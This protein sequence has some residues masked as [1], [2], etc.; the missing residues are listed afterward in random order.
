MRAEGAY[1]LQWPPRGGTDA[2]AKL[3]GLCY[4]AN[5]PT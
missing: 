2:Y 4:G 5:A 3:Q 1:P